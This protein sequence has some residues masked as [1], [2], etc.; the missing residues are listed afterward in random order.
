MCAFQSIVAMLI[1]HAQCLC[2][3]QCDW[4][5]DVT[6]VDSTGKVH[7][8]TKGSEEAFALC[9]GLGLLGTI[10]EFTLQ[11]TPTSKTRFFT[12]Y[13]KDDTNLADDVEKVLKVRI[14]VIW[15]STSTLLSEMVV[16]LC[17]LQGWCCLSASTL[18][19]SDCQDQQWTFVCLSE[20]ARQ[21]HC[22]CSCNAGGCCGA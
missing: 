3:L 20:A 12:W 9:G 22:S 19:S 21:Q 18:Q 10:T 8:S 6:W 17:C 16:W 5:V 2:M 1:S 4:F 11:L 7:T 13:L 14:G 15:M